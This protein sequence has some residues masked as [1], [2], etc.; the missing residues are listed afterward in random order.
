MCFVQLQAQ[1]QQGYRLRLD[2]FLKAGGH[3]LQGTPLKH[4]SSSP[5]RHPFPVHTLLCFLCAV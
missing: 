3:G 4:P 5:L 2:S 1:V